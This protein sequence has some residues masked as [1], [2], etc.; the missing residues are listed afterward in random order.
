MQQRAVFYPLGEGITL[1]DDAGEATCYVVEGPEKALVIDT[2][3]GK[4]DLKA[5]VRQIT[6]KPLVVFNTHGHPDHVFGNVFFEEAY[7][8]K[9]DWPI[10]DSFFAQQPENGAKP[11][12]LKDIQPGDTIDLGGRKLLAIALAGHTPGSLCLLDD[13]SRTLFTGDSMC[14]TLWMQIDHST[15]IQT[16]L[17][18]LNA[19][20]P[21]RQRFDRLAMGHGTQ[22]TP[23]DYIDRLKACAEDLIRTGGEGDEQGSWFGGVAYHHRFGENDSIFY[24]KDKL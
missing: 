15:S 8:N 3:N 24:T 7:L 16:L 4:E 20:D 6:D 1:I 19:L 18:S 22:T 9:K 14:H 5:I 12:P 13:Q 2:V 17:D 23:A 10:H 21:Y 11:C